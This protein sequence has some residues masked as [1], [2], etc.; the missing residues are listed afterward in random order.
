METAESDDDS[1]GGRKS[2]V[3]R[4]ISEYDLHGIGSEMEQYW[5]ADGDQRWS[6]RD[7]ADYFNQ[8]LLETAMSNAGMHS[9]D[10]EHQNH[11]RLLTSDDVS[12]ADRTRTRRRLEREG[13]A[14]E[15]LLEDFVTY[16]AIRTYLTKYREAEYSKDDHDQVEREAKNIQRLR[17]RTLSVVESKLQQLHDADHIELGDAQTL[18]EIKVICM[19]CGTQYTIDELLEQEGCD[20]D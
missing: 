12:T 13:I 17:G 3:A 1:T 10:G 15:E 16:Q 11:Y 18:V 4:L 6:L 8:R 2:K 14:V 20:C 19:E 9:L 7:L 5:T